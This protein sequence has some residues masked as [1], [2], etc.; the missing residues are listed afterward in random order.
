VVSIERNLLTSLLKL[1]KNCSVEVESVNI[2]AKLPSAV[3]IKLLRKL[4]N[5]RLATLNKDTIEVDA[6]NRLRLAIKAINLGADV[7]VI[8]DYLGWQEFEEMA[9]VALSANGYA[10]KKNVRFK[11]VQKRWEI[12]VVGCRKPLVICIDCKHY[13]NSLHPATLRKM[14]ESQVKRVEAF[15]ESLP[16][17]AINIES[18]KWDKAKFI[19]A[20]L[21]LMPSSFKFVNDV[22]VVP[23]L[24]LQD[25]LSQL[26]IQVDSLKYFSRLFS[27][28]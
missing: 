14:V 23:V 10:T 24:Q 11:H 27:H 6:A 19:P 25:F 17:T 9:A 13:H 15:A 3:T 4:Q 22:P 28:L 7:E 8:S 16:N 5:E 26:P 18:V 2:D 12:D 21:T 1:T 20:I